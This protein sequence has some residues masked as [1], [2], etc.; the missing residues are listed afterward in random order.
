MELR[1]KSFNNEEIKDIFLLNKKN[2]IMKKTIFFLCI[3]CACQGIVAQ[4]TLTTNRNTYRAADQIVKQQVEFKDP[5]SSGKGLI[6]DFSMMQPINEDYTLDYF[7]PDSTQ[8]N[9]LCGREH[10]TRYYY[11]QRNDSLWATGFENSTT[12]MEY[13]VPE[14]KLRFPFAYGDTL[15]SSFEGKGEYC[16]SLELGVKGYTRVEADAE[17]EL[18]LPDETVQKALRVRTIRH[19]TETGK[20]SLEMTLD[21]Y[22][23][24]AEGIRYPVFEGIKTTLSKKGEQKDE[25]GESMKDTTVFTTS[26]YYPPEKQI[27]QVE[28][29]PIPAEDLATEQGAASVFTEANYMPNPVETNLY[30]NYK[31]TKPA[32]VWFTL[33]NNAGITL[34]Q[35]AAWNLQEGYNN[36]IVNMSGLITGVYTLYVHVDDMVMQK[37]VVKK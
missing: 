12:F 5:G 6:W 17:G 30:I 8:M 20:D 32:K 7:I 33:H 21:T 31:L 22:A 18:Q 16:H 26:F 1:I 28:T 2:R 4:N 13:I 11:L 15:F 34:R 3:Y 19:Y 10:N 35:T 24:Y 25:K 23:W 27:T 9:K 37:N 14:L 29:D 36:T